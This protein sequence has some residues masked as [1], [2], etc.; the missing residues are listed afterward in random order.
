MRLIHDRNVGRQQLDRNVSN[1]L[2]LATALNPILRY[3]EVAKITAKALSDSTTP[4]E[5][6]VAV[7]LLVPM[8]MI[9]TSIH[10]SWQGSETEI[11]KLQAAIAGWAPDK[12]VVQPVIRFF[13]CN[14]LFYD[15]SSTYLPD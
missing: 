14:I 8:T 6:A 12:H 3:D 13:R 15:K 5:S 2:L 7:G 9:V 10:I 11:A 1:A 4:R